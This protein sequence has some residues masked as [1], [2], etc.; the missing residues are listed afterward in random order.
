MNSIENTIANWENITDFQLPIR[1]ENSISL[2]LL[3]AEIS[4]RLRSLPGNWNFDF[5]FD[6]KGGL[7]V[8]EKDPRDGITRLS[9]SVRRIHGAIQNLLAEL[10]PGLS[11]PPFY[12]S[13]PYSFQSISFPK[14]E[15][16]EDSKT[17]TFDLTAFLRR[18]QYLSKPT[19]AAVNPKAIRRELRERVFRFFD[20]S[21]QFVQLRGISQWLLDLQNAGQLVPL[22]EAAKS[23]WPRTSRQ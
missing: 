20:R 6:V 17:S 19:E 8:R 16:T 23:Q 22:I 18:L 12:Q 5:R 15:V 13:V 2:G 1:P 4:R 7:Q 11:P 10:A 21:D 3:S 14:T 9:L